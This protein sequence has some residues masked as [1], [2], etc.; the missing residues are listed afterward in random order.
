VIVLARLLARVVGIVL[1]ALIAAVGLAAAVFCIQGDHDTLSLSALAAHARL[2]L[3]R[4]NVDAFLSQLTASGSVAWLALGCG[5]AA[6]GLGLILLI[7]IWVTPRPRRIVLERDDMGSLGALRRP[8]ARLAARRAEQ[9]DEVRRARARARARRRR[10]G[11]RIHVTARAATP[12]GGGQARTAATASLA[13]LDDELP[14]RV[15]VTGRRPSR[16]DRRHSEAT[17]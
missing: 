8:L 6:I 10:D 15:R 12:A 9:P 1:M 16:R 3:V 2:P 11:G 13:A 4:G 17:R 14:L 5:I 7:G